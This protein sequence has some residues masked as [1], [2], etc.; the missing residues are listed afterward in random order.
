MIVDDEAHIVELVRVCLE[1]SNY[2]IIEAYD[3]QEAVN[4]AQE[5]H[6]DLILLDIMLPNM[7]GYEVC[8]I[9]KDSDETKEIPIVMLTAK[10]QEVDKVKGFQAGADAYMTKPFSPLR[11][12]TELEEKLSVS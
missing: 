4:K 8:K 7:D 12:L 3:G 5:D 6:P 11:L 10:G 2:D 1:D 9:L